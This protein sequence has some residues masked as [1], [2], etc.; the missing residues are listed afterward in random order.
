VADKWSIAELYDGLE[1]QLMV[2]ICAM[3][4][5]DM[6]FYLLGYID[7]KGF[8]I[9]PMINGYEHLTKWFSFLKS[10]RNLYAKLAQM[11]REKNRHSD[12]D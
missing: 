7:R 10:A 4:M 6:V 12:W 11:F 8:W 9:N 1:I 3:P 2:S 5:L